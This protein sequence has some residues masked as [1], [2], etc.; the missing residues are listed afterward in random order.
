MIQ[1]HVFPS[2]SRPYMIRS[3]H[4][5]SGNDTMVYCGESIQRGVGGREMTIG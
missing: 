2:T 5:G 4:R 1:T 3:L